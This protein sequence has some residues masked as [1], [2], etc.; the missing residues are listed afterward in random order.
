VGT[1]FV[2][3]AGLLGT[4]AHVAAAIETAAGESRAYVIQH[5][6]GEARVVRAVH[7]S[8]RWRRGSVAEDVALLAVEALPANAL[9]LTMAVSGDLSS[10]GAV[11]TF[12]FPEA[13]TDPR[14]P[15]GRLAVD[16]LREQRNGY[17]LSAGLSIAPGTSGSP[18]FTPEGTVV[19]LVVGGDFRAG[20]DGTMQPSGSNANWGLTVTPLQALLRSVRQPVR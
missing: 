4:N 15:Q 10:G 8:P 20:P 18:I 13:S 6:S 12:G 9:P 14:R 3:D 5:A 11:G 16:T 7:I 19:G 2:V 1:A 17:Y